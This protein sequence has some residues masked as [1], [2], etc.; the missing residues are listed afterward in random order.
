MIK[1]LAY[2][3]PW[4]MVGNHPVVTFQRDDAFW[5]AY[6]FVGAGLPLLVVWS[7]RYFC[8]QFDFNWTR[9][10]DWGRLFLTIS[11]GIWTG[12]KWLGRT[13]V[14]TSKKTAHGIAVTFKDIVT[15]SRTDD[16][17]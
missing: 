2:G 9:P 15:Q 14:R 13:S 1:V 10:A 11:V 4:E 12:M 17:N 6:L 7:W 5:I 8:T 16:D 3:L